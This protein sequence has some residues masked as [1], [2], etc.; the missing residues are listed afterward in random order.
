[1]EIRTLNKA[2]EEHDERNVDTLL[3]T[4]K[5]IVNIVFETLNWLTEEGWLQIPRKQSEKRCSRRS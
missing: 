1:M 3:R 2:Q 5:T 4:L